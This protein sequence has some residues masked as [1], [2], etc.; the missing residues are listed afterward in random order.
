MVHEISPVFGMLAFCKC[1]HA[2]RTASEAIAA[3]KQGSAT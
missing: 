1:Q 3:I 2:P